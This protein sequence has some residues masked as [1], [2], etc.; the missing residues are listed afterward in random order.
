MIDK[1]PE[2]NNKNVSSPSQKAIFYET[3]SAFDGE[4]IGIYVVNPATY[5][6]ITAN[7]T[8]LQFLGSDPIGKKC[9][10][11]LL[12]GRNRPCDECNNADIIKGNLD[13][14]SLPWEFK[15]GE[16]IYRRFSKVINIPGYGNAKIEIIMDITESRKQERELVNLRVFKEKA[17][18]LPHV[19]VIIFG[20]RGKITFMNSAARKTLGYSEEDLEYLHIWHLLEEDTKETVYNLT[21]ELSGEDRQSIDGKILAKNNKLEAY[22]DIL[23]HRDLKGIFLEGTMF[24]IEKPQKII[25][26]Y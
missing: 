22:I 20:R 19:P 21:E 12:N 3:P 9:Y 25:R 18:D 1:D 11:V 2:Q 15:S 6:I 10:E 8:A 13:A 23:F 5:E 14:K 26:Y 16:R 4:D 17:E 24:I 7:K